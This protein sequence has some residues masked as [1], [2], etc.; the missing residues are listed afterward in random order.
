MYGIRSLIAALCLTLAAPL[1]QASDLSDMGPSAANWLNAYRS[2]KGRPALSVSPRLTR[3][4][5]GHAADM[6]AR[7]FFN[8]TGSG[9]SSIGD[10]VR[11][12]GYGF[13]FVAE[14][15]AKGQG[16]L[17]QVLSGWA[18]S[19]GHNRNMLAREAREFGLVRGPGNLWVMVLGR[20]GC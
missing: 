19:E 8:H 20:P 4:A 16:S 12:Q 1:A 11:A 7:G 17:D 10:R 5:A 14:N 18:A 13:C 9:G 3:A 6:A 15:I 2:E